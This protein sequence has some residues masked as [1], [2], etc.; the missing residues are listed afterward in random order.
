MNARLTTLSLTRFNDFLK[1]YG[2]FDV[3]KGTISLYSEAAQRK[4]VSAVIQN[5]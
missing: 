4:I 3:E 5:P 2:N 1:A